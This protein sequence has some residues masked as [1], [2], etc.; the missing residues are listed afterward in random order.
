[1]TGCYGLC[2]GQKGTNVMAKYIYNGYILM[3]C[4]EPM[5]RYGVFVNPAKALK[6]LKVHL[7]NHIADAKTNED[8]PLIDES[9]L[10]IVTIR[11]YR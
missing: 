7:T 9:D 8:E 10:G 1:L 3:E 6:K 5:L 2:E 4:G 11:I